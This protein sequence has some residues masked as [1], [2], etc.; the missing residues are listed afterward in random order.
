[1]NAN[2]FNFSLTMIMVED[3]KIKGYTAFFKQ[4]PNIIAE[5]DSDEEASMNLM[6]AVHDVFEFQNMKENNN[7][8]SA[9]YKI[10]ERPLNFTSNE[11]AG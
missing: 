9:D 5:G 6:N 7:N 11:V 8:L 4:F 3:P 2:N 10:I 1:M